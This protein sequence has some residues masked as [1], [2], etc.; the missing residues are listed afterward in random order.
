[1]WEEE[2]EE[3]S[4]GH[5]VV[6]KDVKKA[7]TRKKDANKERCKRRTEVNKAK[8]NNMKNQ[9]KKVVIKAMKEAS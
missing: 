3:R 4:R 9:A 5:M 1:M 6:E 2:R 8:Y 7:M